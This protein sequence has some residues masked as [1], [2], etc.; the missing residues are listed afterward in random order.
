MKKTLTLAA[1]ALA[2]ALPLSAQAHRGW[3]L[4][5]MTVLA[6]E[7]P[8]VTFDAAISN[9]TFVA[10]H[11]PMRLDALKIV[12]PDGSEAAPQNV[13]TLK[14]RSVFDLN[15]TQKGTW[16]L[17]TASHGLNAQWEENGQRKMWPPRGVAPT[18]EGFEKEVPKKA[19]KLQVSQA[20]R[21]FETFV[22]SGQTTDSVFKPGNVGLELVPVTHPNDLFA[23]ESATFRFLIDG[24]P[25]AGAKIEVTPG[26]R[27][28]RNAEDAVEYT[29][30]KDGKVVINWPQAG[31]Y[32]LEAEYEDDKASKPATKRTGR[33]AAVLEVL[34]Q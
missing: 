21:R 6:G 4:P 3:I 7:S 11:N 27:R 10:D 17:Y 16:K 28:Y 20:S 26:E 33:Y 8:W 9:D 25:A 2:L 34:P 30:D 14:Q 13:A 29:T 23:G 19:D 1:V 18:P 15:L 5:S 32:F 12:A 22:T 24:K 31:Q